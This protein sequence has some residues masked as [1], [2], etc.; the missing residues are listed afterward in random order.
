[1]E[2]ATGQVT[3]QQPSPAL[4]PL[5]LPQQYGRAIDDPNTALLARVL[6]RSVGRQSL[7]LV[8]LLLLGVLG[9]VRVGQGGVAEGAFLWVIGAMLFGSLGISA[10]LQVP[11]WWRGR[12]LLSRF[13]WHPVPAM[14]LSDK[15]C[16]VRVTLEGT[17]VTLRLRRFYWLAKQ[18]VLRTG[19]MWICGPDE[20]GRGLVRLAGSVG[21]ALA[22]V[23]E[24]A[25]VG[26][27]PT[28]VRPA[29]PRPGDDPALGRNRR[30]YHRAMVTYLAVMVLIA[31]FGIGLLSQN[32][33]AHLGGADTGVVVGSVF[34]ALAVILVFQG[35]LKG[36]KAFQE[37][38]DAPYW[39]PVPVSLDSWDEPANAALRT[40]AGRVILP[41]G[42]HGYVDFPRLSL[43]LA[44]N[45][46]AT[47]VLWL[48]G[49]AAPG[50][51][52]PIGLPGY[53]L[54]GVAKFRP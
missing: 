16:L 28:L 34:F 39:Q 36:R 17:E 40:G 26:T 43:D 23:T 20:R 30:T 35:Y 53:P 24:A 22:T 13:G 32:G 54:R 19:T 5:V 14:I 18:I 11:Q 2:P 50:A 12:V 42:W 10:W 49:D 33:F 46:R 4:P 52:V 9:Y 45:L 27:P 48:A 8:V 25:P 44:A 41:N 51:T 1:M 38:M 15:P 47:G 37:L 21:N 29:T 31:G 7:L 3:A 6:A